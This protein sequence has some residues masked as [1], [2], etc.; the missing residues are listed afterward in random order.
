MNRYIL[1]VDDQE[2]NRDVLR[3]IFEKDYQIL[4]ADSGKQCIEFAR[5]Y[6]DQ[7]LLVLLD[8]HMPH[9]TGLDILSMRNQ[10]KIFKNTPVIV[11]TVNDDSRSQVRALQLGATDYI[12]KPF[13]KEIAEYRV[14]NAIQLSAMMRKIEQEKLAFQIK[15][16]RD[17]LTGLYNKAASEARISDLLAAHPDRNSVLF[18][19]DLDDFKQINDTFGH[20]EGDECLRR[21]ANFISSFFRSGDIV[22]RFGGDEF[23]AFINGAE[24]AAAIHQKMNRLVSTL[25]K[26]IE[27]DAKSATLSVGIAYTHGKLY[28]YPTLFDHADK[29]LYCAKQKGKNCYYEYDGE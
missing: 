10:G 29:A 23:I 14:R 21:Y 2:I 7:I 1:I 11:I 24:T 5:E 13:I 15:S 22:G 20:A 8:L 9:I 12:V 26:R 16:E 19:F 3:L 18:I 6:G 25:E 27:D 17:P 4:E 28:D